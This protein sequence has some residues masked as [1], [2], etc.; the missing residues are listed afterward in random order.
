M[1]AN[2][3]VLIKVLG[4]SAITGAVLCISL[5]GCAK[6]AS[7]GSEISVIRLFDIFE[8]EDLE[9]NVS[10]SNAGWER[11]LWRAREMSPWQE[12]SEAVIS[13]RS[14]NDITGLSVNGNS[15]HGSVGGRASVLQFSLKE[16]RGG[17]SLI[18]FIDVRM[19]V[20]QASDVWLKPVGSSSVDDAK[21]VAWATAEEWPI[22]QTVAND[23]MR[24]YRFDL[25]LKEEEEDEE[26]SDEG[27]EAG[28]L[29]NFFLS[30]RGSNDG[31]FSI[32]SIRF[33]SEKEEGLNTPSGQQWAGLKGI[34]KETLATKSTEV[35]RIPLRE[36]PSRPWLD[37]SIGTPEETPVTFTATISKRNGSELSDSKVILEETIDVS[38]IWEPLRIDL[39]DY[40][41]KSLMLELAVSGEKK[42]L[43]GY[44][45]AP[46]IRSSLVPEAGSKKPRGVIFLVVDTLRADHLNIY[47]YERETVQHLK[48][49][50]DEGV[51]FSQAISQGTWTKVSQPSMV[52]SL[53]PMSHKLFE[54][55]DVLPASAETIAEVYREA[56]YATVS[57]ASVGF[58]GKSSNM[59]QGYEELHEGFSID[60]ERKYRS[61]TSLHYVNRIIPWLERHKDVPFFAYLH[62]F[63]PHS[64]YVPRP[65]YDQ[66]WGKPGDVEWF[67]EVREATEELELMK[68]F[69]MPLKKELV[70]KT[71]FDPDK[72]I[73]V[74]TDFYDG[75]IR[76][77]DVEIGRLM[78]ALREMGLDD[79]TL[80][81]FASDHGEEL[82]E[83]GR[84]SHGGSVYGELSNVPLV[85]RWPNGPDFQKGAMIDRPVQNLDIMPTLLDLSGI[86]GPSVMQGRSLVPLLD[87]SGAASWQ[88][89]LA[90]TQTFNAADNEKRGEPGHHFGF[91][92]N[93]F[94]VVRKEI[95]PELVEELYDTSSDPLEFDNLNEDNAK[96]ETV[97]SMTTNFEAWREKADSEELPSDEE[98][99][100]N[101]GRLKTTTGPRL[102]W[103]WSGD[104]SRMKKMMI[105]IIDN[106]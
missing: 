79:D 103:G 34:F 49:F 55:T 72:L 20:R 61:K 21:Q 69:E 27:V 83:R 1:V 59:H 17:T 86:E 15:L 77:M 2:L 8:E 31:S 18:K 89:Q 32:D 102:R 67:T 75:S 24:I 71:D 90:I 35:L 29:R 94:K 36:L 66:V 33:V 4:A 26:N 73:R 99:A 93:G 25:T 56:G 82:Y 63:D 16:N 64:P 78:E 98:M 95:E 91:H 30:F 104:K 38:E 88:D 9:G 28:D 19:R 65:P 85:F 106:F 100:Q 43:W 97:A 23:G 92:E 6:K 54:S 41:G 96:R 68:N 60:E 13:F 42:G 101:L 105:T 74:A 10:L 7:S 53:Y 50:A 84:F 47:G 40:V 81:V 70:E 5:A 80:I 58:V 48:K 62:V 46:A 44:W 22:S 51:A 57:Y 76:G 45:G 12:G 52:T 39:A 87:G 37:V 11:T 14:L 3:S